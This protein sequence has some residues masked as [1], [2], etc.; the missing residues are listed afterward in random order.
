[1]GFRYSKSGAMFAMGFG[2]LALAACEGSTN[3]GGANTGGGGGTGGSGGSGAGGPLGKA[4]KIDIVL[5]IDN[6]RSMADKQEVL[7]LALTDL[8]QTL[9]NPPCIDANGSTTQPL[10][11]QDACPAGSVRWFAPVSDLH[12]GIISSSIGGFGSDACQAGS[13]QTATNDDGGRL[14]HRSAP[15]QANDLPTYQDKGFLLWDPGAQYNPPG[16]SDPAA[17][18]ASFAQMVQGVGQVGCGYEATLESWY[19][20]LVD[21][22]PYETL[23]LENDM[24]TPQG[25][26]AAL[27]QQRADFLRPD[28]MLVV[29]M[30]SD[31]NDCSIREEGQYYL[32]AQQT[33][34]GGSRFHL[35]RPRSE[36]AIDPNDPCCMSCGQNQSEC[37][38]DPTCYVNGDPSQGVAA[39][40]DLEDA[41]NLRCFDQKRRFG[42][43]FLYPVDRYVQAL[44]S[45]TIQNRA[46]ELVANPLFS[47]LNPNDGS[48][49]IRDPGLVVLGGIVGVPWQEIARDP[50]NLTVGYKSAAELSTSGTWSAILGDPASNV[51]PSSPYM[52]ESVLPRSGVSAGNAVNGGEWTIAENNDLQ[53]A[54]IFPLPPGAERDCS[55]PAQACDCEPGTDNPLCAVDPATGDATL[56]VAAKAYPSLRPLSVL[57]GVGEQG[58]TS[59]ICPA[60]LDDQTSVDFGYRP[61]IRA[62]IE[63]M[64]TR[65]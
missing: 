51:A 48:S 27:L 49:T 30:L 28:S 4:E 17:M 29:M 55:V 54:C 1:M 62:L 21:P 63:R 24:V 50:S 56:Q 5:A 37:P 32:S 57:E 10:S 33:N 43:D 25:V 19:R 2:L 36:C 20:F 64:A 53:Y 34:P 6:S 58:V 41:P 18:A 44:T 59:S 65:L 15:D 61:A 8:V 38:V 26:D 14:I 11:P 52:R 23:T 12:L 39:L 46:G 47:D 3:V 31:E 22:E 60:Q 35:P 7:A 42:I 13:A 9:T 40:S 45:A 16:E